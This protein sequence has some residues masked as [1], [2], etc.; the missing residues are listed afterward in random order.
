MAA[1]GIEYEISSNTFRSGFH[2][3][4]GKLCSFLLR[5]AYGYPYQNSFSFPIKNFRSPFHSDSFFNRHPNSH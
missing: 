1:R 5:N 2:L 4:A 3:I